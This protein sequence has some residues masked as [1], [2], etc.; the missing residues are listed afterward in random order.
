MEVNLIEN[1][2]HS[3]ISSNDVDRHPESLV[4]DLP[5]SLAP[6]LLNHGDA[7]SKREITEEEVRGILE[8]IAA[9]GKFWNDWDALK[10]LLSFWLKQVWGGMPFEIDYMKVLAEYPEAKMAGDEQNSSLGE[11]YPELVKRLDE[12][13]LCFIEG[14]PFTLQRLCEI[15]LAARSIYPNLS[16]LA[17]ALEKNLLVTST[18]SIC[19]DPYPSTI[20]QKL[21]EPDKG[22]ECPQVLSNPVQNGIEIIVNDGDEEMAE[23]EEV[24]EDNQTID[25]EALEELIKS[26]ETSSVPSTDSEPPGESSP[27]GEQLNST[28]S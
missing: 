27:S 2:Q 22:S 13:L 4:P 3:T 28:S 16:K 12:A 26:S 17:L 25:M 6:E 19:T 23:A 24:N 10:S 5:E 20:I 18:L 21:D 11:T 9:T 14:P 1:S 8:V 7:E 15:L